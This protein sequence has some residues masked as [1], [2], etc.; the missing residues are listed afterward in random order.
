M[1][2][3]N[4]FSHDDIRNVVFEALQHF[5]KVPAGR[6]NRLEWIQNNLGK[7]R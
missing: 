7:L 2:N 6:Q 5:G 3:K 4:V 1:K